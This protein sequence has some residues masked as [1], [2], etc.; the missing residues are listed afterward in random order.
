MVLVP[1]RKHNSRLFTTLQADWILSLQTLGLLTFRLFL[2]A[3]L[4][5]RLS[6][7]AQTF[8]RKILKPPLGKPSTAS[9]ACTFV[10]KFDKLWKSHGVVWKKFPLEMPGVLRL[11]FG[12]VR[13]YKCNLFYTSIIFA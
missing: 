2:L 10:A 11:S 9:L 3:F 13:H 12:A 8:P 6:A 1:F 4:R 5:E 7:N